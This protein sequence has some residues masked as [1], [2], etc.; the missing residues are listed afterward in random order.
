MKT[1]LATLLNG[2]LAADLQ[3]RHKANPDILKTG[4]SQIDALNG[5]LP[6]GAIT[7]IHGPHSSGRTT[8]LAA[9]LAGATQNDEV[10]ALVDTNDAFDPESAETSG[11]LLDRILWVRCKGDAKLAMRVMDLIL[12]SGGFGIVVMDLADTPPQTARR[13]SLASWYRYRHAVEQTR[14]VMIVLGQEPYAR[15]CASLSL[16]TSRE[17]LEWTGTPGCSHLLKQVRVRA[18]KRKPVGSA[19]RAAIPVRAVG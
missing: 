15:Q 10:C 14:T 5:G 3:W 16:E 7:E 2:P 4:I 17:H 19:T 1:A 9:I 8:L 12:Q 13:I 18:D 6:R 11:V